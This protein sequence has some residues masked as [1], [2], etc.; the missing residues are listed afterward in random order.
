MQLD[1]KFKDYAHLTVNEFVKELDSHL[2]PF[3]KRHQKHFHDFMTLMDSR[4]Q[5][6]K[7][8][9]IWKKKHVCH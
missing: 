4:E 9:S 3:L 7:N 5:I 2:N 8:F 1:Y 6:I